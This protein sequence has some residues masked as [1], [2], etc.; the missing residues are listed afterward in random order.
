MRCK[1]VD[2]VHVGVDE[3]HVGVDEVHVGMD[4]VQECE[5]E[6]AYECVWTSAL[7]LSPYKP[8]GQ[9]VH[10][11]TPTLAAY[12]PAVQSCAFPDEGVWRRRVCERE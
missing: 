2:E 7:L 11:P 9:G 8:P 4:E 10:S 6:C 1:S 5:N 3:V 12:F